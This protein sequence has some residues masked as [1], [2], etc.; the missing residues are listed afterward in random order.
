MRPFALVWCIMRAHGLG[1]CDES[2]TCTSECGS[3]CV[4]G[5]PVEDDA[6]DR[7]AR[8][9]KRYVACQEE[10]WGQLI[11]DETAIGSSGACASAA[12]C[13]PMATAAAKHYDDCLHECA[14]EWEELN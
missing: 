11:C 14:A 13:R 4:D 6:W 3:R 5:W 10:H 12:K 7:T 2:E 9:A 1:S 8:E